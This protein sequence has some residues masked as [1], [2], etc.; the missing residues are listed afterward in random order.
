M[1]ITHANESMRLLKII[2]NSHTESDLATTLSLIE[3]S[4]KEDNLDDEDYLD[5]IQRLHARCLNLHKKET[6][7][8][9]NIETLLEY[10]ESRERVRTAFSI[11]SLYQY[12][13]KNFFPLV[14]LM[15]VAGI[16]LGFI[17]QSF[18]ET[19][20]RAI[21]IILICIAVASITGGTILA[22]LDS[23]KEPNA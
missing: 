18:P 19:R 4:Y 12:I 3:K 9:D 10:L 20:M 11:D 2:N 5:S 15:L 16:T 6:K 17:G 1:E 8:G 14:M 21:G 7:I 22:L 23:K 13:E